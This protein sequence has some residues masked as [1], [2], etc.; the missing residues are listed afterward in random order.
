MLYFVI[1]RTGEKPS[2]TQANLKIIIW[3][4]CFGSNIPE[5]RMP[6]PDLYPLSSIPYDQNEDIGARTLG[7]ALVSKRL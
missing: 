2:P 1:P 7:D 6:L 4:G 3:D 5:F